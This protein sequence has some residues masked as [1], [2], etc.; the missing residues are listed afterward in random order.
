MR[1]GIF[2]TGR[3]VI[4]GIGALAI[5]SASVNAQVVADLV[6]GPGIPAGNALAPHTPSG[7]VIIGSNIWIGDE[8]QGLRHYIPVDPNNTDPLNKGQL[9]FDS[10]PEF[11]V[12]GGTACLPWCSVGQAAQDGSTLAFVSVWDHQKGQ[13]GN[14]GGPGVWLVQFQP[15]FGAFDAVAG[16]SPMASSFGLGGD[17]PTALALGP[18]GKLYVGFLKNGNIKRIAN[19][20][21][22][23]PTSQN[24]TVES[25]GGTPNGRPMRAMAFLGADLYVATDQ[26]LAVVHNATTCLN[27]SGG[28]G[29]AVPVPDGFVGS[30]HVGLTTD[31]TGKVY[32]LVNGSVFRY[33]PLDQRIVTVSSGFLFA[34]GHTN[35]ITLDGFG[36]LWIGDDPAD[37]NFSG[38]LW[39]IPAARLAT[40]F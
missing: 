12:G 6:A 11:S 7:T 25:V 22:I 18:D 17:Q 20:S 31:G 13:P 15:A 39:R 8:A 36:N 32:F 34:A 16:V 2:M 33:T 24:Q 3:K 37:T 10:N 5:M 21:Q 19:P 23:N 38:R 1:R 29:N 30:A 4:L 40:V 27:N 28:C 26:G 35:M 9:M 14:F